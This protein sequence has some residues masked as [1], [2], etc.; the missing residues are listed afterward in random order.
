MVGVTGPGFRGTEAMFFSDFWLPFSMSDSLA[1]VG[2][3]GDR[4]HDRGSE[5]L[6]AAGRLRD[7]ASERAAA[8]EIAVI[9]ERLRSAYPA[10][11]KDRGFHVER[12]G[13]VN[14][15]FEENDRSLLPDVARRGDSGSVHS[16]RQRR[17]PAAGACVGTPAESLPGLRSARVAAA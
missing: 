2:M 5:W 10:T 1:E 17:Q 15:G 12:A 6:M 7:G 4:L 8:S 16:L 13:Q 11:Y 9:G 3:G 14:A